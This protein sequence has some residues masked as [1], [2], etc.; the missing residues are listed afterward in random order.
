MAQYQQN[1]NFQRAFLFFS[2]VYQSI[3]FVSVQ[4]TMM[5]QYAE[6]IVIHSRTLSP[7]N[8]LMVKFCSTQ[9]GQ[10]ILQVLSFAVIMIKTEVF[11][12]HKILSVHTILSAH[13]HTHP[14]TCTH[15][16]ADYTKLTHKGA[17]NRD[18][19][20]TKTAALSE[21][22]SSLALLR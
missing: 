19:R 18:L 17:A 21:P 1:G 13:M 12:K 22:Y 9:W 16:H 2:I 20:Q 6:L 4:H 8:Y 3:S 7:G 10:N 15:E 11:I 14:D 5:K